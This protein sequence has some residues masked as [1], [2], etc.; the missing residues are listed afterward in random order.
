MTDI[1]ILFEKSLYMY[2]K[3]CK[4]QNVVI[5]IFKSAQILKS[6]YIHIYKCA[7]LYLKFYFLNSIT[8]YLV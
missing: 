8:T 3:E 6:R 4:F 5:C 2:L 1:I 7:N